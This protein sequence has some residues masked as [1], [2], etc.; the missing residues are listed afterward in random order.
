ML[1]NKGQLRKQFDITSE[2]QVFL[3]ADQNADPMLSTSTPSE[4]DSIGY[5]SVVSRAAPLLACFTSVKQ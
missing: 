1:W 2:F 3:L 5:C 4:M